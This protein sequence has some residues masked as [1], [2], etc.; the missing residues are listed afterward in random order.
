MI[1]GLIRFF[2]F[3]LLIP[4]GCS[5]AP[6]VTGQGDAADVEVL[7]QSMVCPGTLLDAGALW[8]DGEEAYTDFFRHVGIQS[9]GNA[10]QAPPPVDFTHF[11]VLLISMGQ[12]TS[13]GY[14]VTLKDDGVRILGETAFV[15]VDWVEP[16]AGAFLPQVVTCPCLLIQLPKSE[17]T[18]IEVVDQDGTV[19]ARTRIR[20]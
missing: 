14:A 20:P 10:P 3:L 9:L 18:G 19:R 11:G 6:K 1:R 2:I 12:R 13:G 17:Y 15:H 5:G 16:P 8:M 4:G 7:Y